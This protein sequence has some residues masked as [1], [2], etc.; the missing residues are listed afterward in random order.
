VVWL[1]TGVEDLDDEHASAAARARI[2]ERLGLIGLARLLARHNT[3]S[4][5]STRGSLRGS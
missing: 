3:S 1:A 2:C 5:E 4:G